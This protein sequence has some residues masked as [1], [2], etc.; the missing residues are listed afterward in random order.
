MKG[1]IEYIAK[2]HNFRIQKLEV[3]SVPEPPD[4]YKSE[5]FNYTFPSN[6]FTKLNYL[7][8][9]NVSEKQSKE[10]LAEIELEKIKIKNFLADII[11]RNR[12]NNHIFYYADENNYEDE[13]S[14]TFTYSL[15][16]YKEL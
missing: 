13:R 2:E 4:K 1:F 8:R 9:N 11:E 15:D 3:G 10:I 12:K 5:Q 7:A 16:Y 6:V 14:L